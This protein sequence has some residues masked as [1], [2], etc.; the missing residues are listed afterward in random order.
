MGKGGGKKGGKGGKKGGK[1][2]R[3]MEPDPPEEIEVAGTFMHS[4]EDQM[5]AKSSH[6]ERVPMFNT[7]VYKQNKQK[8]GK[9]DEI[10]GQT[11]DVHFSIVPIS[12]VEA[13]SFS[14]GDSFYISTQKFT[15]LYKF[16]DNKPKGG[17]KGGKGKGKGGKPSGKGGKG[18]GKGGKGKG[19]GKPRW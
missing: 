2:G 11:R 18:K 15:P 17:K 8:L 9:I 14:E 12:G 19:G 16:A 13:G 7:Y 5:I 1:G 4:A 10:L 3:A 6:V